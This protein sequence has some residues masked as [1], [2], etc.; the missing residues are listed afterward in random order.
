VPGE[1]RGKFSNDVEL[2]F[3]THPD[4][5]IANP[6]L[7]DIRVISS[8]RQ[9]AHLIVAR[10]DMLLLFKQ[11]GF[12]PLHTD[13]QVCEL[14]ERAGLPGFG[15]AVDDPLISVRMERARAQDAFLRG[16]LKLDT[17][18]IPRGEPGPINIPLA[19]VQVPS[20]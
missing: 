15:F 8:S 12:V 2:E 1:I 3:H 11:P 16:F 10:D 7:A 9:Q 19:I 6:S 18:R 13:E 20:R 17:E 5:I 4:R 14:A